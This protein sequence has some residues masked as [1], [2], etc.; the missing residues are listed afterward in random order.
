MKDDNEAKEINLVTTLC[1]QTSCRLG[2]QHIFTR[3]KNDLSLNFIG[4]DFIN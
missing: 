1:H 4:L 2:F 3:K